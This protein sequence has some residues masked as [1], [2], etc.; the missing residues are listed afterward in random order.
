M[1][2]NSILYIFILCSLIT[3]SQDDD[4]IA[5]TYS[6]IEKAQ[7]LPERQFEENFQENYSSSDFDYNEEIIINDQSSW[8]QRMRERFRRWWEGLFYSTDG[9]ETGWTVLIKFLAIGAV[10]VLVFFILRTLFRGEFTGIF[11]RAKSISASDVISE[12]IHEVD[13]SKLVSDAKTANDYRIAVRFYYLWLLKVMSEKK[14]IKWHVDK[15]NTE[16]LYEIKKAEI[17]DDF[18]YLSYVF[19]Y[20]WYGEFEINESEFSKIEVSFIDAINNKYE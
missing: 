4:A 17:R 1:I 9:I 5:V 2:R 11:R 18:R 10:L 13:F 19:D 14:I 16:Y 8:L 15:T 7:K 6:S 12:N 3:Y 20:C